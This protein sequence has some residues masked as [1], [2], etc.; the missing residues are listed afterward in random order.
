MARILLVE[1]EPH[2]RLAI[3]MLLRAHHHDVVG[4]ASGEEAVAATC[5]PDV[6]V[7]DLMLPG[8]DG[9]EV[10]A[11]LHERDPTLPSVVITAHGSI[12]SAVKAIRHGAFDYLTKPFDNDDLLATLDRA[13]EHRH[14]TI[15]VAE[16][17][18]DLDA[19]TQFSGI[20]G[21]SRLVQD[22]LR[23]LARVAATDTTVLVTGETG[24]GKE[25]IARSLHRGSG[26][27]TGPFV[28]I[29]CAAIPPAL[30]ESELFGHMRGAFT[31]AKQDRPGR[32]EEADGG[33]LFLDEVGDVPLELQA[34]LLRVL[35]DQQ[36]SRLGANKR[37]QVNVRLVAATHRDLQKEAE[38][39]RFRD[40]LY[41]RLNVVH[42]HMPALRDRPEDIPLLI[43]HLLDTINA[44][45]RTDI[46]GLSPAV[47]AKLAAYRWPGNVRQLANALR[48]AVVMA[49]GRLIQLD[50]LPEY[51]LGTS[52]DALNSAR[53]EVTLAE[54][55]AQTE[56][57]LL[58]ATLERFKGNHTAAARALGIARR[59]LYSML[60]RHGESDKPD[61]AEQR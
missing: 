17:E 45:C 56:R 23:K 13:V 37:V 60:K 36:V 41:W 24:T 6:A 40:D 4:V 43:T 25:L 5:Q 10:M 39:G 30:A 18:E 47:A 22:V 2:L 32:F 53:D 11:R 57:Q 19:R 29:N 61:P 8:M 27:R 15:R 14:L 12:P 34:K 7:L 46:V 50:D 59:T 52:A 26:R 20:V 33:T 48:H 31:D 38:R 21:R 51:L 28:A 1:D 9:I 35:Q 16:L 42:L 49:T 54:A 44:E 3:E 58:A 55:L